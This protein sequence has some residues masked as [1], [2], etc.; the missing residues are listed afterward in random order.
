MSYTTTDIEQ[1]IPQR[2]PIVM[3]DTF[4][5]IDEKNYAS[6]F[7][8]REDNIFCVGDKFAEVGIIE[9]IA[10]TAAAYTGYKH[11]VEADSVKLGY[12]GDVKNC[13]FTVYPSK[14]DTLHTTIRIVSEIN[15]ITLITAETKVADQLVA[16]CK[17]KLATDESK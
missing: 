6:E 13:R 4:S 11:L 14:G 10:Q 2:A 3:L 12:I 16:T 17:M 5:R 8:I 7:T 1:L 9:H 15:D